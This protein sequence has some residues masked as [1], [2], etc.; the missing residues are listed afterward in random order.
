LEVQKEEFFA[1]KTGN[2]N[3]EMLASLVAR[4]QDTPLG[5]QGGKFFCVSYP[6]IGSVRLIFLFIQN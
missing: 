4:T 2:N 1:E 6:F 5:L 3:S